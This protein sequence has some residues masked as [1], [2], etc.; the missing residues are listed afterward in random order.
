MRVFFVLLFFYFSIIHLSLVHSFFNFIFHLLTFYLSLIIIS[1]L[2]LFMSL[3]SLLLL[4]FLLVQ[5]FLRNQVGEN[6]KQGIQ[7]PWSTHYV[8]PFQSR[9][10]RPHSILGELL[11]ILLKSFQPFCNFTKS[12]LNYKGLRQAGSIIPK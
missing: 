1:L 11:W 2:L 4:L 8:K 9:I 10:Q 5:L 3:L 7:A 12:F 6:L